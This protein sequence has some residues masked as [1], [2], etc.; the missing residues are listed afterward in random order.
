MQYKNM[1]NMSLVLINTEPPLQLQSDENTIPGPH[2]ERE[3]PQ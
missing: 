1:E 3:N 2:K